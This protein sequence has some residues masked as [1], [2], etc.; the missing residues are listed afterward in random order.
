MKNALALRL[1][2]EVTMDV[3][4]RFFP[5]EDAIDDSWFVT[6]EL[7]VVDA[8]DKPLAALACKNITFSTCR[9]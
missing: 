8:D 4:P 3:I 6:H 9:V 7:P 1:P 5:R 2:D